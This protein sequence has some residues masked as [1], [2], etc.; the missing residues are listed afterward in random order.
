[1]SARPSIN[2]PVSVGFGLLGS[3]IVLVGIY[4]P[5]LGI[6]AWIALGSLASFMLGT[7]FGVAG[8]VHR[9]RLNWLPA[10]GFG[11][12][13]IMIAAGFTLR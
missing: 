12:N 11:F 1:M 6:D 8:M 13:I 4:F 7:G 10:I 3:V 2:G 5:R 9:E